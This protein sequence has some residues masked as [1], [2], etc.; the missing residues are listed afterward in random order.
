VEFRCTLP[1][2]LSEITVAEAV[3][4]FVVSDEVEAAAD[5]A[6][7]DALAALIRFDSPPELATDVVRVG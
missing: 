4:A 7:H 5:V 6:E 2:G 3:G 1:D